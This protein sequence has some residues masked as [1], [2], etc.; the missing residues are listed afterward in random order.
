[1]GQPSA[2]AARPRAALPGC[3][4]ADVER[5]C[6]PRSDRADPDRLDRE[7]GTARAVRDRRGRR[8][9]RPDPRPALRVLLLVRRRADPRAD[10]PGG[11]DRDLVAGDR[12]VPHDRAHERPHRGHESVDQ[13]GETRR[14]WIPEPG[15]LPA[16]GKV[17]LH[18][19][20]P[21]IVS[22]EPDGARLRLKSH[23][24]RLR[25][26]LGDDHLFTLESASYLAADLRAL[27]KYERARDLDEDTVRRC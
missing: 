21:P 19:A 24:T 10:H 5:V 6:R 17:A 9:S 1:M 13:A 26:T 7:G 11:D 2:P 16:T 25:A 14:L 4:G 27:G 15:E 18:P 23:F 22:E 8:A 12:G 20:H 3:A